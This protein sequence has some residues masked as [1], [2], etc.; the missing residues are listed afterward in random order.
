MVRNNEGFAYFNETLY[1]SLKIYFTSHHFFDDLDSK[2]LRELEKNELKLILNLKKK[3]QQQLDQK[4]IFFL[5]S[6]V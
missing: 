6:I 5:L 1:A 4:V 2:A 3:K